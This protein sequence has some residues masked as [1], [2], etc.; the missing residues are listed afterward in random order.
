MA[1]PRHQQA[2][3]PGQSPRR[4]R[5]ARQ[6]RQRQL[7]RQLRRRRQG[8]APGPPR[9]FPAGGTAGPDATFTGVCDNTGKTCTLDA[10]LSTGSGLTY[11][12]DFGDGTTGTS[13]K[14]T[15]TYNAHGLYNVKLTIT[16]S[17]GRTSGNSTY[18]RATNPTLNEKPV[19]AFTR[20]CTA[21]AWC[22]FDAS[23]A[24]DPDGTVASYR[25]DFGDGTTGTS[26]KPTHTYNA[27]GLYNVKL[28]ITDSNGRTSGNSTYLR[29]TNPTLNEKPVAAFTRFCTAAAW[30][31]FDASAAYDPDGTVASYRW[32]FGD[33]TT[34]TDLK[35]SHTYPPT[36]ATY[37]ARLTVTD[38]KGATG[39]T[40]ATITCTKQTYITTCAAS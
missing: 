10:G 35:P 14:P 15:H 20:F 29:A 26:I 18:L 36:T 21:A 12:W 6:R 16:D 5:Q 37:T 33:G 24:Y 27:H 28:T 17:N 13:I 31:G 11:R 32:D 19:A 9:L 1:H 40:T 2:Q 22:G 25:W 7:D 23:A 39:T 3:G 8:A 34:A 38:A 4:T 30:C